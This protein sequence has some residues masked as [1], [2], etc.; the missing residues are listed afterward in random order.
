MTKGTTVFWFR[1]DL[2]LQDNA[3][4]FHAL[5]ESEEVLPV[6]IFDSEILEK[7]EDKADLR[8][9]FIHQSLTL[10]QK[11]LEDLGSTLLVL[12]GYPLEIFKELTPKAVYTNHDYEPYARSRDA[13][14]KEI[15]ESKGV[16]FKTFKD[17][18]IFEKGE[19]TKDDGKPYTVF[20]PYSRKWKSK[21]EELA[22]KSFA[23][24]KYFDHFKKIVPI[25]LPTLKEIGFQETSFNF[26]ERL[27]KQSIVEQYDKQRNF[28]AIAG[29]TKLS[30][31]LRFGTVSIRKLAQLALEKNE[32]WLNELIW[33]D[34]YHMI[35]WYFPQVET[36]AFKPAYDK[37]EWRNN[38][39][40]FKAWCEGKTGY[41]IVDA[42]MRELNATG[43]MHNRV[44]MIT[45]SF[46]TKHL[47]ID[48]RWGEAYFAKKL[49][50]F[51]LA[52]NNGGWQWAASSGCDAA[53]YFRVFNPQLQTEKFDPK[54]EYIKKWVPEFGT[55]SY[56]KPIVDHKLARERV[57][58]VYKEALGSTH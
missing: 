7:L 15:L 24:E 56:P 42:G 26:P 29:T 14:V 18:V 20:T 1:R 5:K 30:V 17:Q 33:R 13:Q 22:L 39:K 23:T 55:T 53:P 3:G 40:E 6:F 50:D 44:R 52:A 35:L 16:V 21:L 49:L 25:A 27:V 38:E 47:L 4:L 45:A 51:D 36:K 41:P 8:V 2:R 46:L 43:F 32:T 9:A 10:M 11:Q 28:P 19:V 58:R 31:H 57:L 54:M 34:F 48:W 37:I 12:H